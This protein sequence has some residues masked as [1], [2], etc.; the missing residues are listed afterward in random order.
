MNPFSSHHSLAGRALALAAIPSL[1]FAADREAPCSHPDHAHDG[2]D[3][4]EHFLGDGP[5]SVT[6]THMH[7]G[8]EWMLSYRSMH[9]VMDGMRHG[10]SSVSPGQ[11]FN[12][13]FTVSPTRMTMDMRMLGLMV[14]P[15]DAVTLM[16]MISHIDLEMDHRIFPGA[17]PLVALNG[18]RETFT[19]RSRGLGDL[20]LGSLI[21]VF[22]DGPHHLHAGLGLSVPTA[23]IGA[24]DFAPGPGGRLPRQLPAAMQPGSGTLDLLPALTYSYRGSSWAAG[25]RVRG[26]YRTENNHHGYRLG[27]RFGV[28]SWFNHMLCNRVSVGVGLSYLREGEVSG[29]QSDVARRPPFAPSRRT[30]PTAFGAHYGGRRLEAI[31]GVNLLAPRGPLGVHRLSADLRLPLWEDVNGSRLGVDYTATVGWQYA[32]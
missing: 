1:A 16:A 13:G 5:I 21:R 23:S 28:D 25:L 29:V 8:G 24:K 27:D 2:H 31:F 19:T 3:H 20:K 11:V 15:S 4:R 18:G 26:I 32:F 9:M 12:A 7:Q 17:A 22:D 14:A 10:A 6:G 30:V